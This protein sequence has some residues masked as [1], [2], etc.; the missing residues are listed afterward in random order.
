VTSQIYR[1]QVKT[2]AGG[3]TFTDVK[4]ETGDEAAAK[5]LT[6]FPG[7]FVSNVTPAPQKPAGRQKLTTTEP[8]VE[9]DGLGP[10]AK[11]VA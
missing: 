8:M 2:G 6:E 7:G 9:I 11:V 10:D 4:A 1:V 5:A 3:F